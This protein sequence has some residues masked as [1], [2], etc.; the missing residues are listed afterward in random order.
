M[1]RSTHF[2]SSFQGSTSFVKL[3]LTSGFLQLES[4]LASHFITVFQIKKRKKRYK[5]LIFG[6]YSPQEE[7]Q[8]ALREIF[9][10]IKR[11]ANIANDVLTNF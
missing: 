9:L 7:L 8:H 1:S 3:S 6:V 4:S 5:R 10:D 11:V 2:Y